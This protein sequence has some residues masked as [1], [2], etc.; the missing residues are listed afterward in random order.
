M[1]FPQTSVS[2]KQTKAFAGMLVDA[3]ACVVDSFVSEESSA[4]IPFG[5]M[6]CQGSA[7][8]GA[9]LLN[10]SAAAMAADVMVG[11]VVHSHAYQKTNELGTSGLKPKATLGVLRRGIVWVTVEEAVT[12][13]S[14]VKVRA[15][16]GG[17]E[18]AGAFRD[19]ADSTDCVDISSF[20]RYRTTAG[21]GELAQLEID[22]TGRNT[23]VADT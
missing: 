13:A 5:V 12:P 8:N 1:A 18:Q 23:S 17:S 20:A 15:V 3:S 9:K 4:E 10:T 7:D 19:T 2:V 14:A 22:M 11:V 6:V 21:A 16:A